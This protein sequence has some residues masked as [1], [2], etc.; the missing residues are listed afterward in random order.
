MLDRRD[1]GGVEA[2]EIGGVG[3][4]AGIG[5]RVDAG[6]D[7]RFELGQPLAKAGGEV[8]PAPIDR[9]AAATGSANRL[10]QVETLL[11]GTIIRPGRRR[12][13]RLYPSPTSRAEGLARPPG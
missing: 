8:R 7:R 2:L 13:S 4:L 12:G 11:L 5:D 9:S 6:G 3:D 1:E 10:S